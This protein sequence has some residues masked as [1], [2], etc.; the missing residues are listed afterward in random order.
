[1]IR[2][3]T[4]RHG[5]RGQ[6]A[7]IREACLLGLDIQHQDQRQHQHQPI[8]AGSLIERAG[9]TYRVRA[10]QPRQAAATSMHRTPADAGN[11]VQ[12]AANIDSYSGAPAQSSAAALWYLH[13]AACASDRP[14]STTR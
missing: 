7:S 11:A 8:E 13:L 9:R 2:K 1:M 3:P 12:A 4:R 6:H 14:G 10:I 5:R